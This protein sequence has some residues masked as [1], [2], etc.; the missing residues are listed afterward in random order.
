MWTTKCWCVATESTKSPGQ[1]Y[2]LFVIDKG[3]YF[4]ESRTLNAE[5]ITPND[6]EVW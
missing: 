1:R 2:N 5:C 4:A 6:P 3:I